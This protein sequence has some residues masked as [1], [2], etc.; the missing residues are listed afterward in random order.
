MY[1]Y[2]TLVYIGTSGLQIGRITKGGA[3]ENAGRYTIHLKTV[4]YTKRLDFLCSTV[5]LPLSEPA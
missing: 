2:Q 5:L 4:P 3:S 1:L